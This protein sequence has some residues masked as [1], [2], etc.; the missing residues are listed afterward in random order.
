MHKITLYHGTADKIVT[1]TFG[2]GN[3]RHDYGKGFY[4]TDDI[5]LAKEW[6][7]CKPN[8]KNGWVHTYTLDINNLNIF[9]FQKVDILTWLAELMKHRNASD[10]KRY[11]MLATK[12]ISKYG[13]DISHYDV[14]RGWRANASYFY[15]AKE[16]VRDNVDINILEELLSL[17]G[18]GI[19]YCIKSKLAY[20]NLFEIKEELYNIEYYKFNNKYNKRDVEARKTMKELIDS[21]KNKVEKV[22]STLI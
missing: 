11:K 20:D 21:D 17:G 3:D 2:L 12:F 22:F 9:D 5:E 8:E 13:V 15:I 10:S 14:I 6:A 1:P 18:L 4:L 16:F 7:V 19:Q